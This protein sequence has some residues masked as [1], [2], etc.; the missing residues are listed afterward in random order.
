MTKK[1]AS[2]YSSCFSQRQ[3]K[4]GTTL[5]RQQRKFWFQMWQRSY[6][7]DATSSWG[8]TKRAFEKHSS[9]SD[10]QSH[11]WSKCTGYQQ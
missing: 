6:F 11:S 10:C 4:T 8:K 3:F 5:E 9:V 7:A 2:S 1:T